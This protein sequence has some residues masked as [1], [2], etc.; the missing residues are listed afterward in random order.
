MQ[1]FH[2]VQSD[3]EENAEFT[4]INP[5]LL[6]PD[7][8][9]SDSVSNTTAVSTIIDNLSLPNEE[10]YKICSKLNEVQQYLFNFI[11]QYTLH[12]KLAEKNNELPSKPF[13]MFLSGCGGVA[14][15]FLMRTITEY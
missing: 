11:M 9:D 3:E 15:S 4:M 13:Q 14:K 6:D 7:L 5:N 1:N 2:F 10:F 8:E 12:H